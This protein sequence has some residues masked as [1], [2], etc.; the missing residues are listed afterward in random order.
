MNVE[1]VVILCPS[2]V[3]TKKDENECIICNH[4]LCKGRK[5]KKTKKKK[6]ADVHLLAIDAHVIF[7]SSVFY[8]NFLTMSFV[9]T[10]SVVLLVRFDFATT[11]DYT[12]ML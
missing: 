6:R 10:S 11:F 5:L 1:L 12:S 7:W 2:F 8:N 9:T 3:R 4:H